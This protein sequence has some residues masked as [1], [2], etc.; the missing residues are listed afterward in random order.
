V[1]ASISSNNPGDNK[2]ET[3]VVAIGMIA[4]VPSEDSIVLAPD[5]PLILKSVDTFVTLAV[6]AV[7]ADACPPVIVVVSPASAVDELV[8]NCKVVTEPPNE[9]AEP[10]IVIL[11]FAKLAF[12]IA[13]PFHTPAV[14]VPNVVIELAPVNP[15][16]S[17]D[18][19]TTCEEPDTIPVPPV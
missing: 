17:A 13:V 15:V 3:D 18:C 11:E 1:L 4:L 16:L 10:S 2:P 9:I 8:P 14:I 6:F 19:N 5:V 7:I 12:A